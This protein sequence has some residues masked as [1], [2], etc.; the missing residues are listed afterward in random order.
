MHI[1]NA[2]IFV[3]LSPLGM[4]PAGC[5]SSTTE[6]EDSSTSG[7]SLLKGKTEKGSSVQASLYPLYIYIYI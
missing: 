6:V 7:I 3:V 4:Q 5:L 2:G 1:E